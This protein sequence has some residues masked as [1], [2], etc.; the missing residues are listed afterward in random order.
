[1]EIS[2]ML[3]IS[4]AHVKEH[5]L[6]LLACEPTSNRF[7]FI[8]VY[9][10]SGYGYF[11]YIDKDAFAQV[12]EHDDVPHDL[13]AVIDFT[14]EAGCDILCLDCDGGELKELATYEE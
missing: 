11:V 13:A 12:R 10:K 2:K 5:T 8:G 3:T 7:P 1:M 4:T 9:P 14:I 6:M